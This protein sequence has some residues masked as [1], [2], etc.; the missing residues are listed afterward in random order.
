MRMK[1]GFLTMRKKV[2]ALLALVLVQPGNAQTGSLTTTTSTTHHTTTT[3]VEQT[4]QTDRGYRLTVRGI[5]VSGGAQEIVF[6]Q[7]VD[8]ALGLDGARDTI[9]LAR[10]AVLAAGA[11]RVEP[12]REIVGEVQPP[13]TA[14]QVEEVNRTQE[15][16]VTSETTLGP[17]TILV[18]EDLSETFMIAAGTVHINTNTHTE[19]FVNQREVTTTTLTKTATF[20]V[21]GSL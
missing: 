19:T 4:N 16:T 6:E 15:D 10:Q 8:S 11:I 5:V 13:A 2:L 21:V 7:T 1:A 17:A 14:S 12:A 20:D 3:V 9:E 18:G